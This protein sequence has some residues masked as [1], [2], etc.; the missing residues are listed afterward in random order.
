MLNAQLTKIITSPLFAKSKR[1]RELLTYLIKQ[2]KD[3]NGSR[4]KGYVIALEVFNRDENFDPSLDSIVRVEALRLRKKLYEYYNTLGLKDPIEITLPK[5]GYGIRVLNREKAD[6]R[7]DYQFKKLYGQLSLKKLV[8]M[9][10]LKIDLST[11]DEHLVADIANLVIFELLELD[12]IQ[13]TSSNISLM[14]NSPSS[15]SSN[16]TVL[17]DAHFMLEGAVH[18]IEEKLILMTRI[19]SQ[20][21]DAYV[22]HSRFSLNAEDK[23]LGVQMIANEV[24][25]FLLDETSPFNY[26][27]L[28]LNDNLRSEAQQ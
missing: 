8:V 27:L 18:K 17:L 4:I 13:V 21:A 11:Q 23:K 22:W 10:F 15:L 28:D 20:L 5:G 1:Q 26:N 7:E 19:Y 16:Q 2:L 14:F 25:K 9:P 12:I 24:N 3:G 6:R